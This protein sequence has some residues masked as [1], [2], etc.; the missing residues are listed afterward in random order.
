[1][2]N[3]KTK[4]NKTK[5]IVILTSALVL[6]T[7]VFTATALAISNNSDWKKSSTSESTAPSQ[8]E[9]SESEESG[10]DDEEST[11]NTDKDSEPI[12]LAY[13][14][15]SEDAIKLTKS[16]IYS[17]Y[18][19]LVDVES[20]TVLASR[21][22]ELKMSPAS[23]TKVM[24]LIVAVENITDFNATYTITYDM[25]SPLIE[26]EAARAGFEDQETVTVTDLLYGMILPSGAD[27]TIALVN[28]V[29]ESEE[30]FVKL[31]NDKAEELGM[32]HTHFT[33]A[34][35]LYD[36]DH[37]STACD[38]SIL[39]K[40]AMSNDICR[41]ILGT[42][43]YTTTSTQ[44]HPGGIVLQ[45]TAFSRMYGS[46]VKGIEI[47]GA[48]TGFHDQ[49]RQCLASYAKAVDG[50]EY[51][52]I[53]GHAP[54]DM[55]TIWDAFAIYGTITGTYDMPEDLDTRTTTTTSEVYVIVT[56][57]NGALVTDENG[58]IV[59]ALAESSDETTTETV[60]EAA[61]E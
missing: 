16:N 48:K 12:N 20:N 39:M 47:I 35:G 9:L 4:S 25:I 60:D 36:K 22:A 34:T 3:K 31:M 46:E 17:D 18:A 2:N 44:Q 41:K 55:D 40:T 58:E 24:T 43:E 27:A 30:Q 23:I 54:T 1:M 56:D 19:V 28:C 6:T 13:P 10:S 51:V 26:Q 21:G 42:V 53:T 33:N 7:A 59:T 45:S 50:K 32:T 38:L 15:F 61:E 11:K 52:L 14:T 5:L 57:E 37:Y 8:N 49:A 29:S